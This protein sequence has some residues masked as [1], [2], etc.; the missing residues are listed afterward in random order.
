MSGVN[1]PATRSA[2]C[3]PPAVTRP[4]PMLVSAFSI[5]VLVSGAGCPV[6]AGLTTPCWMV[7]EVGPVTAVWNRIFPR[8]DLNM[9]RPMSA[10]VAPPSTPLA[11]ATL[12]AWDTASS[13]DRPCLRASW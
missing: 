1:R 3:N 4:T 12:I 7:L 10:E 11:E 2:T 9:G 6:I 8:M 5:R 13:W